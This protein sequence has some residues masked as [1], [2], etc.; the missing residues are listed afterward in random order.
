M[1][2]KVKIL[3]V[4]SVNGQLKK[5]FDMVDGIQKKKGNFDLLLCTGN[6]F[7]ENANEE[8][9][10]EFYQEVLS[11]K[12]HIPIPT[13]FIDSTNSIAPFMSENKAHKFNKNLHF[14]G[15]AGVKEFEK[16][17]G[18]RVAFVSGK[19][20]DIFGPYIASQMDT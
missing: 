18:L 7:P 5:L 19:D 9:M 14:L 6:L 15:R 11:S 2:N 20:S 8:N 16:L 12:S 4:G 1:D 3:I 17:H 13:Y 10:E